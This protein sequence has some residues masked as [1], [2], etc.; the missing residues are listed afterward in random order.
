MKRIPKRP[1]VF[2][3][4]PKMMGDVIKRK[5]GVSACIG[6]TRERSE[7]LIAKKYKIE[8]TVNMAVE[9]PRACQNVTSGE[10]IFVRNSQGTNKSSEKENLAQAT[11]YGSTR[12]MI[13]F[14]MTSCNETER[15][16]NNIRGS[17]IGFY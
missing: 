10:G 6:T 9:N 8:A 7:Y 12:T 11:I 14:P 15:A 17:H 5:S 13:F 16:V 4:S 1:V 2:G 3:N